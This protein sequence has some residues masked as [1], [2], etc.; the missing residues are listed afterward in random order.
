MED[1]E[2]RSIVHKVLKEN[3]FEKVK[4][5][6]YRS[7]K[8]FL[9]E[10]YLQKSIYGP[11]FYL[12]YDFMLGNFEKPYVFSNESGSAYTPRVGSRFYFGK[13]NGYACSFQ[14][15]NQE[16]VLSAIMDNIKQSILPPFD[17]GKQYLQE[18][19]GTLYEAYINI[20]QTEQLLFSNI[21]TKN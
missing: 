2:F 10:I 7:E 5:R 3:G 16:Q 21:A 6:Y 8:E 9:C 17:L 12:N 13:K 19:Y 20:K 18:H 11:V 15:W 4:N 1:K 14:D